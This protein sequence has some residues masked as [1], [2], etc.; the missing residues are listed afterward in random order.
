[1]AAEIARLDAALDA[2]T[3]IDPELREALRGKTPEER[4]RIRTAPLVLAP[5]DE[6]WVK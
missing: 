3:L 4:E 6:P 5:A 2:N 1:M